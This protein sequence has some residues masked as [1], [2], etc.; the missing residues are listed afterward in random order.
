M[1]ITTNLFGEVEVDES[2]II[3]F[4]QGIVGFPD[5]KQFMLIHDSED[6]EKKISWLQS[7]DETC[8]DLPVIDPLVIDSNYN[9]EIEDELLRPLLISDEDQL[10]VLAT[11]TVPSDITKMTSNLKA[12]IIINAATLKAAQLIVEDEKYIV[13]YPIYD[14]LKGNKEGESLC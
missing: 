11:I 4:T 5:L 8:F 1:N 6:E 10:L 3:Y 14:I 12:P 7:I 2:K 13:K 9:P